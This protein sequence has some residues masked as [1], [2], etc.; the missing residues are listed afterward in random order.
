PRPRSAASPALS[1]TP[2]STASP[3]PYLLYDEEASAADPRAFQDDGRTPAGGAGLAGYWQHAAT[4]AAA[5][6]Y[7]PSLLDCWTSPS[8]ANGPQ[9]LALPRDE[10]RGLQ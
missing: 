7:W 3:S 6:S 2:S 1:S 10:N 5:A 9:Q 4:T 8:V